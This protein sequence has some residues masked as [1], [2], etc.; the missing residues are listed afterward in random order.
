[1][2]P[3]NSQEKMI[4]DIQT[5]FSLAAEITILENEQRNIVEILH[6]KEDLAEYNKNQHNKK[7]FIEL[8]EYNRQKIENLRILKQRQINAS[9][10]PNK[11][12]KEMYEI[13]KEIYRDYRPLK[14]K[15]DAIVNHP[16]DDEAIAYL[17][18]FPRA[19]FLAEKLA[20]LAEKMK[21]M[22]E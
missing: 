2:K 3:R 10:S 11:I 19:K 16:D 7:Q 1:M 15:I 17:Q 13:N 20:Y 4:T 8:L 6:N 12:K 21:A 14:E 22:K 18:Q 5:D 9:F